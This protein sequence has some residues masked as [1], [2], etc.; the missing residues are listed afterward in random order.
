MLVIYI[1][2]IFGFCVE[3]SVSIDFHYS[4][5]NDEYKYYL[6]IEHGFDVFGCGN[7]TDPC[8]TFDY[9]VYMLE[10]KIENDGSEGLYLS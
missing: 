1:F 7:E 10:L 6:D 4:Q 8:K 3:N 9:T 2:V 5:S